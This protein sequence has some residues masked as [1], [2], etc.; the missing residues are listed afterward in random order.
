MGLRQIVGQHK[1]NLKMTLNSLEYQNLANP[2]N[3]IAGQTFLLVST[4]Q[5]LFHSNKEVETS[6]IT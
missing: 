3:G 6:M 5:D 1:G 4:I 2:Y